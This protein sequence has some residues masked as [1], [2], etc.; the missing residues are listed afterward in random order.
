MPPGFKFDSD[1]LETVLQLLAGKDQLAHGR[2]NQC[3]SGLGAD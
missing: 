2:V 3:I 1:I